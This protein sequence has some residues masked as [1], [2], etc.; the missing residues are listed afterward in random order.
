MIFNLVDSVVGGGGGGGMPSEWTYYKTLKPAKGQAFLIM[1]GALD[2]IAFKDASG[3][4]IY[5]VYGGANGTTL[6]FQDT[7]AAN[8][9]WD[10]YDRDPTTYPLPIGCLFSNLTG[11]TYT[12]DEFGT[13]QLFTV[14]VERTNTA[15]ISIA[16]LQQSAKYVGLQYNAV[17]AYYGDSAYDYLLNL[18]NKALSTRCAYVE[19]TAL[20]TSINKYAC[21]NML[22]LKSVDLG[23]ATG[24]L[25]V[26]AFYNCTTLKNITLSNGITS[27]NSGAFDACST[28]TD[29]SLPSGLQNIGQ[30][31][32]Q[33]CYSLKS[34]IIPT[35]VTSGYY[36]IFYNCYSLESITYTGTMTAALTGTNMF[37]FC[38][39]LRY[40]DMSGFKVT[41]LECYGASTSILT[42]GSYG[43][44]DGQDVPIRIHW[45]DSLG[46]TGTV[47]NL[48]YTSI[49]EAQM[50][51]IAQDIVDAKGA[52]CLSGKTVVLTG[53]PCATSAVQTALA[54][55]A[56]LGATVTI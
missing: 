31:T 39:S 42:I 53:S 12:D 47:I 13:I 56:S 19:F 9:N 45:A 10:M 28:L 7:V 27:L 44:I 20:C 52:N 17:L 36:G 11:K 18:N 24:V 16:A 8:V 21:A 40:I 15:N 55:T 41:S 54:D 46:G 14:T 5:K 3:E 48:S 23:G 2:T 50:L 34:I 51:A 22:N 25:G 29:V 35:N 38:Q 1:A 33:N 32:F 37:R 30:T 4:C 6:L 49:T 26:N 43:N